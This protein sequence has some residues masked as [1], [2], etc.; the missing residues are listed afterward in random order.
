MVFDDADGGLDDVDFETLMGTCS[1]VDLFPGL[2]EFEA[3]GLGGGVPA[4]GPH[5]QG[6]GAKPAGVPAA[7]GPASLHAPPPGWAGVEHY[8]AFAG[9]AGLRPG[10]RLASARQPQ[11]LHGQVPPLPLKSEKAGVVR[12]RAGG[13]PAAGLPPP[14]RPPAKVPLLAGKGNRAEVLAALERMATDLIGKF[15][16]Q[17]TRGTGKPKKGS[18]GG[19]GKA[20]GGAASADHLESPCGPLS[21]LESPA[22]KGDA[23]DSP[24]VGGH[25]YRGVT[26]HRCTGRWEAHIWEKRKQIYLGGFNSSEAAATA[27]DILAVRLK[28]INE[29]CLNFGKGSY[30]AYLELIE[31]ATRDE[32]IHAVRR[33][34]CGFSRGTSRYRGVTRRSGSGRWEARSACI[35]GT[36]KY[37]Y[38]GTFDTEE[39]AAHAYDRAIIRQNA[40]NPESAAQV[41]NFDI[42]EYQDNM[43]E[44]LAE[45][46]SSPRKGGGR[47]SRKSSGPHY[48]VDL[49]PCE[50]P[51]KRQRPVQDPSSSRPHPAFP[52]M[53]IFSDVPAAAELFAQDDALFGLNLPLFL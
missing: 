6:G 48:H 15:P 13:G 19:K 30:K 24:R 11:L 8:P 22:E 52:D 7:A 51:G 5:T 21:P 16:S 37:T 47:K 40:G 53:N 25:N 34:S 29:A 43:A 49:S 18:K 42:S 32:I 26:K 50:S 28:G 45:E 36:R 27:Y 12:A 31:V 33:K 3:D 35:D 17:P 14:A 9:V 23:L 1:G 20:V 38:L 10:E 46:P 41:T 2:G 4:S 44:I 39:E